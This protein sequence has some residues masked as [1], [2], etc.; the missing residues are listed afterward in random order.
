[1]LWTVLRNT[2]LFFFIEP[3]PPRSHLFPYTTLFR[4]PLPGEMRAGVVGRADRLDVEESEMRE[5][6]QIVDKQQVVRLHIETGATAGPARRVVP[7]KGGR[8]LGIGERRVAH[9]DPGPAMLLDEGIGPHLRA[10]RQLLLPRRPDHLA[11]RLVEQPVIAAAQI[12]A[13]DLAAR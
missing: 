6:E 10:R 8:V 13:L 1:M 11:A 12:V 3:R 7:V 4:S 9:P 5:V 2:I